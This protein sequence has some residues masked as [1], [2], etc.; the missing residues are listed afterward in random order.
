MK[1]IFQNYV[2]EEMVQDTN[3]PPFLLC[4]SIMKSSLDHFTYILKIFLA[5]I[6]IRS[7]RRSCC[8]SEFN[9]HYSNWAKFLLEIPF[10]L[11]KL[12][13]SYHAGLLELSLKTT[14]FM[15][16]QLKQIYS[17]LLIMGPEKNHK[18]CL[19]FI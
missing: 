14:E 19:E 3:S 2:G 18:A 15:R 11:G 5:L 8:N 9:S 13:L 12:A 16:P 1:F 4:G 17:N 10:H 7:I 6:K